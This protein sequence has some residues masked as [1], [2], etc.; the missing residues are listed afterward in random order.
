MISGDLVGQ[1]SNKVYGS[2]AGAVEAVIKELEV[3]HTVT[4]P[5]AVKIAMTKYLR[6]I[7]GRVAGKHNKPWQPGAN[8]SRLNTRSGR[9][10]KSVIESVEVKDGGPGEVIGLIGGV[11]YLATQEYGA[12]IRAKRSKYLTIPLPAALDSRG[13]PRK[14][15][16]REWANTFIKKSKAGNLIIFQK[17]AGGIVPLYVLKKSVRIPKRLGLRDELVTYKNL[18]YSFLETEIKKEF[19]L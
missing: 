9:G 11:F 10:M 7:A 1:Y 5:Q 12:V 18:F 2:P 3:F 4:V 17:R 8:N 14:R 15:S 6:L 16:A 19:R 13:V